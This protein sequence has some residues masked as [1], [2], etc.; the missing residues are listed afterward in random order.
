METHAEIGYNM[1]KNSNRAILRAAAIVSYGHH[2][3]WGGG[4]YP[5]GIKGDE[6]HIF[7]RITS[8]AD[9]FDALG[10]DRVYKKAWELDKILALFEEEKGKMFEPKLVELF[11]KNLNKFLEIKYNYDTSDNAG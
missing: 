11:K 7:A 9:V 3:K 5:R 6:I 2:E 4:G 8:V 1:L 10:S